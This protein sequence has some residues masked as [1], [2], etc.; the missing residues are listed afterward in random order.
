MNHLAKVLA[1]AAPTQSA[2][3][4]ML[5]VAI[6]GIS[7]VMIGLT[8]IILL[9]VLMGKVCQLLDRTVGGEQTKSPLP[10]ALAPLVE[11]API[12]LK[13]ELVAAITAAVAEELGTDVSAFRV[14]SLR[15]VGAPSAPIADPN[16]GELI[17][18]VTAA[19]AEELGTDVSAIR[20][21]SFKKIG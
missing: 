17:A 2:E 16:R 9:C 4:G 20:V 15:R 6:L 11:N 1:A 14:H 3:P 13:G 12:P 19:L 21:H 18:A 5:F 10:T 7:I 8:C